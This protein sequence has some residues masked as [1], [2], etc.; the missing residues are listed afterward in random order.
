MCS[1][2]HF[3]VGEFE[4]CSFV[5]KYDYVENFMHSAKV[6]AHHFIHTAGK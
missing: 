5:M 4:V 2:R 3:R 1:T 6:M